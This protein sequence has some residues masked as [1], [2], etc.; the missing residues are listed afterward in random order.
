MQSEVL[1]TCLVS[2]NSIC[3]VGL[4]S[5]VCK[6][7]LYTIIKFSTAWSLM[8]CENVEINVTI[9]LTVVGVILY[10]YNEKEREREKEG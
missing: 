5:T 7:K 6:R 9:I 8:M 3:Y 1:Y 2:F 4:S 10:W